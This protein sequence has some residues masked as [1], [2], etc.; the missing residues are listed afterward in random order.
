MNH[1][2]IYFIQVQTGWGG[3]KCFLVSSPHM[4]DAIVY[5]QDGWCDGDEEVIHT[6]RVDRM[7]D[8]DETM[9]GQTYIK[10]HN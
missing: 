7:V 2:R 10:I 6:E 9:D 4:S 8:T 1:N 5:I 3:R